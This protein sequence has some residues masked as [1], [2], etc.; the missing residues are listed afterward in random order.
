M[1]ISNLKIGQ[2]KQTRRDNKIS[3]ISCN[4]HCTIPWQQPLHSSFNLSDWEKQLKIKF[5]ENNKMDR[6]RRRRRPRQA[7]RCLTCLG[8]KLHVCQ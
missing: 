2:Q 6:Q 1:Q 7:C 3:T 5:V 4:N 8:R